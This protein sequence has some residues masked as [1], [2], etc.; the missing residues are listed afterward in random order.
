MVMIALSCI[1][2]FRS[3]YLRMDAKGGQPVIGGRSRHF[4]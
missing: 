2:S 1:S 4:C 3:M